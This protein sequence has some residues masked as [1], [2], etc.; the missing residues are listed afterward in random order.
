[1]L[2]AQVGVWSEGALAEA[3]D[4]GLPEVSEL[5]FIGST[6]PLQLAFPRFVELGCRSFNINHALLSD[7]WVTAAQSPTG[8]GPVFAWTV[9]DPSTIDRMVSIGVAAIV[10]DFPERV[11]RVM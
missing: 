3:R 2:W 11:P 8:V 9:N 1:M 5:S 4:L 10:T 7:S 6:P